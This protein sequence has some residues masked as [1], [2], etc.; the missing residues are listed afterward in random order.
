MIFVMHVFHIQAK[1]MYEKKIHALIS[2]RL[3]INFYPVIN[4]CDKD[5]ILRKK[6]KGFLKE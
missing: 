4:S 6:K 1:Y 3:T 2:K 5:M